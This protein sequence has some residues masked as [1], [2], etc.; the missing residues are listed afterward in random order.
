M[1]DLGLDRAGVTA[2]SREG[3]DEAAGRII[4]PRASWSL[5]AIAALSGYLWLVATAMTPQ[6]RGDTDSGYAIDSYRAVTSDRPS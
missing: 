3:G 5:I 4:V 2:C 1:G 6:T